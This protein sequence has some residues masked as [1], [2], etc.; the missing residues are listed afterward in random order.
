MVTICPPRGSNTA[1]NHLLEK[2]KDVNFTKEERQELSNISMEV[3]VEIPHTQHAKN[4]NEL[5]SIDNIRS[6]ANG[7]AN[8]PEVDNQGMVT[9]KSY[10]L[11]GSF[12]TP[13]FGGIEYRGDFYSGPKSLHYVLS[14]PDNIGEIIGQGAFVVSVETMGSWSYNFQENELELHKKTMEMPAAEIF[15][16]SMGGHLASIDSQREQDEMK[17]VAGASARRGLW[18]GATRK[19]GNES[20]QWLDG[21]TW[22]YQNWAFSWPKTSPG[23]DCAILRLVGTWINFPC[24]VPLPFICHNPPKRKTGYHSLVFRKVLREHPTIHFW[25][26]YTVDSIVTEMPGFHLN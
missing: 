26:N 19:A 22:D 21:T 15:C 8:M 10:E 13:G 16:T 4:M 24:D 23:H 9:I 20:W 5:L 11:Q 1:L 18:L 6:I 2:V 3:F 12:S 14:L 7:E 25:W 17:R